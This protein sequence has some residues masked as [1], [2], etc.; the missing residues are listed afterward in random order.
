MTLWLEVGVTIALSHMLQVFT[1]VIITAEDC[2]HRI[3]DGDCEGVSC[4]SVRVCR[5][6]RFVTVM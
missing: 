4:A 3:S 6:G 1:A 2:V 5:G